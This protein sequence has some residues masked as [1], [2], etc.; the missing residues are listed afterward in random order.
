MHKTQIYLEETLFE[1]LK[2]E[3]KKLGISISGYIRNTIKEDI[4][5]KKEKNSK[6]DFSEFSGIWEDNDISQ[7]DIRK[8]AWK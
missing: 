8:K 2:I 1:E 5:K 4:L 3:A 7:E 6:L